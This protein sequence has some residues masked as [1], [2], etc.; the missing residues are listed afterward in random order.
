M[1]F[2]A[3]AIPAA[4]TSTTL[5]A[6]GRIALAATYGGTRKDMFFP[7]WPNLPEEVTL[8]NHWLVDLTAQFQL[9]DR[10]NV[11][12]RA[13]NLLDAEY[14]Q[15]YGYRRLAARPMPAWRL[16]RR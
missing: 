2:G 9:T 1:K 13:N 10:I 7:P 12:A 14:E 4:W 16:L 15:V 6:R 8:A 5:E 3:H 11:F